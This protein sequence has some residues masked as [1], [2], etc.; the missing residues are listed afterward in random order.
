MTDTVN[1]SRDLFVQS[2]LPVT[3]NS[4][5]ILRPKGKQPVEFSSES[6]MI[7]LCNSI[8]SPRV[9]ADLGRWSWG[10]LEGGNG[11]PG[12]SL[13]LG[14]MLTAL[15]AATPLHWKVLLG[16]GGMNSRLTQ[17]SA[18]WLPWMCGD[19]EGAQEST[20]TVKQPALGKTANRAT[21]L[22]S[23]LSPFK[24]SQLSTNICLLFSRDTS[25]TP[26]GVVLLAMGWL[27]N[28]WNRAGII[29]LWTLTWFNFS[30]L[31]HMWL[32]G[33][34]VLVGTISTILFGWPAL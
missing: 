23:V 24:T 10:A 15:W 34:T 32:R 33:Q 6:R 16:P 13:R 5:I 29:E 21:V 18:P 7:A 28:T 9:W 17:D 1:C 19:R 22:A 12:R 2:C 11:E 14:G 20:E 27:L 25:L 3:L 8:F 30:E 31:S 26:C 4:I